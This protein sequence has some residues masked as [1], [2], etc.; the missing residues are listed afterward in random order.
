MLDTTRIYLLRFGPRPGAAVE[1]GRVSEAM[2]S[3]EHVEDLED[4]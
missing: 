2:R 1:S 3:G 4:T